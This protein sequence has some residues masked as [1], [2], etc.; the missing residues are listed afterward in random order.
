MCDFSGRLVAWMDGELA[1]NEAAEIERHVAACAEC[2]ARVEAYKEEVSGF[3]AYCDA[4]TQTTLA[5]KPHRKLPRWVPVAAGCSG[6]R[7]CVLLAPAARARKTGSTG[8]SG[9]IFSTADRR[10]SQPYQPLAPSSSG[11]TL[12][13]TGR[14]RPR[15]GRWRIP[16][17][18]SPSPA[19]RC[20][21]PALYPRESTLSQT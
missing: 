18:R 6:G 19:T 13:L 4:T 17:F 2:R 15:I 21:L 14:P 11:A 10:Y 9:G 20:F 7:N 8:S 16:L 1:E 5:A 12:Q 3:A